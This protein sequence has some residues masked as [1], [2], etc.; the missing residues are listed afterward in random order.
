[1]D[2]RQILGTGS[3]CRNCG[4][5][6]TR[7]IEA[8]DTDPYER[9]HTNEL[10]LWVTVWRHPKG[11]YTDTQE[12]DGHLEQVWV[13]LRPYADGMKLREVDYQGRRGRG[14]PLSTLKGL[15]ALCEQQG[16]ALV[17]RNLRSCFYWVDCQHLL[18]SMY[19]TRA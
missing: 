19:G 1:M 2:Q 9:T 16:I 7:D 14:L 13:R 4:W 15:L 17:P 12:M 6:P 8:P 3:Y 10:T 5:R 18:D 11:C